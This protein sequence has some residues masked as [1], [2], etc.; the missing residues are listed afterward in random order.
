MLPTCGM[1]ERLMRAVEDRRDDVAALTADLIRFPTVNPP[2]D[3]YRPCAE[4]VAAR[5]RKRGFEIEFVRAEGAPGD[6][7]RYPRINVVARFDGRS[8]GATVHFNSHIDV[9]DAGF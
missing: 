7:E 5:L 4:F 1:D 8:P 3:G 9:V 2:G 6:S